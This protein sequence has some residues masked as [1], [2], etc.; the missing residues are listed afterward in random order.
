MYDDFARE[1][2]FYRL[3]QAAVLEAIPKLQKL[4][5]PTKRPN[6]YFAEMAKS[7]EH[8]HKVYFQCNTLE[9]LKYQEMKLFVYVL[10]YS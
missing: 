7:D 6:D 3:G 4:D 9:S 1:M 5:I 10:D 8:M 2:I